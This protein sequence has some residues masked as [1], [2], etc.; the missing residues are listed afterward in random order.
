M[1]PLSMYTDLF[2]QSH[3]KN[4]DSSPPQYINSILKCYNLQIIYININ[5]T[6]KDI[7]ENR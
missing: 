5:W 7:E 3:N 2:Y 6:I 1:R 4:C